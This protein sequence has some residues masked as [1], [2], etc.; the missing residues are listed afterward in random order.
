MP[1]PTSLVVDSKTDLLLPPIRSIPSV[2]RSNLLT[3]M[4]ALSKDLFDKG[5]TKN[6]N[7]NKP[8]IYGTLEND[9]INAQTTVE[10][11]EL[12]EQRFLGEFADNGI[13]YISGKGNDTI[14]GSE[15]D[16][17]LDTGI[18][19]DVLD[20]QRGD[21]VL[22]GGE[23]NDTYY[24]DSA[25]DEIAEL[26]NQG[27]DKLYTSV[28]YK[29]NDNAEVEKIFLENSVKSF[30][31]NK[32]DNDI[33]GNQGANTIKGGEGNDKL[34][35]R[36]GNDTLH[37][38]DDKDRIHGGVGEDKLFGDEGDDFLYG[39]DGNDTIEGGAG[40]DLI[41]GDQGADRLNGGMG[42]DLYLV[43]SEDTINDSG[44][45]GIVFLSSKKLTGG[46]RTED[47]PENTY[48]STDG[49]F[50]YVKNGSTL[51]ING[52][53]TINN[54][55]NGAL[56]IHL[57]TEDEDE[58]D[59]P[60]FD[61]PEKVTSPIIIDLD[62]D[63][64]ETLSINDKHYFDHDGNAF[65]ESTGW[66]SR[67]DGLLVWDK[68]NNGV[69]D[70][71]AELFG[72]Q[73]TLASGKKAKQGYE[74]L[75]EFD[76]NKDGVID[77]QDAIY[78][79]LS[80]WQDKN[81]N[82]LTDNDEIT[83]LADVGIKSVSTAYKASDHIDAEGNEHRQTSDVTWNDGRKTDSA[84]VWFKT[85][86]TRRVT[87]ET[88]NWTHEI[89]ALPNSRG[90]G[91]LPDLQQAMTQDETLLSMVKAFVAESD[92]Q[93]RNDM[94]LEIIY[95]WAGVTDVD[96]HSRD[97]KKVYGHVIDARKVVT[98]EKL[99]GRGYLGTWCWGERD[100]NPHGRAAPILK[101]EFDKFQRSVTAQ[102]NT[103]VLFDDT[104]L[105]AYFES[106]S[107]YF[108]LN[109]EALETYLASLNRPDK[110]EELNA[111]INT[112][113]NLGVYSKR[114]RNEVSSVLAKI[115][116]N[117]PSLNE[118]INHDT[119]AGDERDN[120]LRDYNKIN[121]IHGKKGNDTLYGQDGD[122]NYIFAKGDG[123]DTIYDTSGEDTLYFA[124][125]IKQ[126]NIGFKR[127][128]TDV[129]VVLLDDDGNPTGDEIKLTNFFD[130]DGTLAE[131][132]IEKVH[133]SDG[134]LVN[135]YDLLKQAATAA[136]EN[137][138]HLFGLPD[139]D[140]V[141]ALGGNDKISTYGGDDTIDGGA[142]DDEILAGD[143][144]DT[145]IGGTGNDTLVGEEGS[146]TYQFSQ[147]FGQD[148]I[149]NLSKDQTPNGQIVFDNTLTPDQI[150]VKRA[151]DDLQLI[152]SAQ[153]II[154]VKGYFTQDASTSAAVAEIQFADGTVWD[155]EAIKQQVLQPS[156]GDDY[157][158][159]YGSDDVF[160]GQAGND[161][162]KGLG[163]NDQLSGGEG[164]DQLF[165]D[166]GNDTLHGGQGNDTLRGG[167]D[168]D[169][170]HGDEGHDQLYGDSGNDQLF[171][172]AGNDRLEG[173]Y[174]HDQLAGGE[175]KDTLIGGIGNDQLK[176]DAG[177]DT[178]RG[179]E[180]DDQLT[181]GRGND[182]LAGGEGDDWYH[183]AKG[184]GQDVIN[185][186]QGQTTIVVYNLKLEDVIFR[187][188]DLA[189]DVTFKGNDGD[190]IRLE[191]VFDRQT[192]T[193]RFGLRLQHS[194]GTVQ[195]LKAEDIDQRAITATE[196]KDTLYGNHQANEINTLRGD[197]T[198]YAEGGDDFIRG[199]AGNDT[200]YGQAG[201]DTLRGGD[202]DDQLYGGVGNDLLQA[203]K[204]D[205]QLR[206][207][208]GDDQLEGGL[209][210]D[211]LYG[212]QGQDILR[213]EQGDDQLEGGEGDDQ[214][215]YQVGDG[216]DVIRDTQG[217]D[218]L[219]L[220]NIRLD[221]LL[222]RRTG[223]QYRY[224]PVEGETSGALSLAEASMSRD[225]DGDLLITHKGTGQTI[226]INDQ[227]SS[228]S[229]EAPNTAIESIQLKDQTLDIAAIKQQA[230]AGTATDDII[231]GHVDD[232]TI[233]AGGGDDQVFAGAGDDQ[234]HG[235][236]GQD[237]LYGE[238]G[239][240]QLYGD[241]GDDQLYGQSGDDQL[242][243]GAGQ[244]TLH[245]GQGDDQ[246]YG[247]AGND[248]LLGGEGQDTLLGGDGDDTLIAANS[249][250]DRSSNTLAGGKGNDTLYGGAGD[251]IYQFNLGDGHDLI[252]E[253]RRDE[254][255]T[256]HQPS[257]DVLL[258]GEG[259]S[260]DDLQFF[261]VNDDLQARHRNGQDQVTIQNWFVSFNNAEHD[262]FKV[263]TFRF[264]DGSELNTTD[265]ESQITWEGSA[266]D[267][268]FIGYRGYSET[269]K[270]GDG[271]DKVFTRE[272]DDI[273][274]GEGGDD[275]LDG[276]AG[277]DQ[278]YGGEGNDNLWGKQGND[279]L[280]GGIGDDSLSGNE[281]DDSL[282]G[283]AGD[284]SLFGGSGNDTLEGG[285]G[286]D[287]MEAGA[288]DDTLQGG[289]GDDQL[290]GGAG[291]DQLAGGTGSDKYIYSGGYDVIDN[292]GGGFD[293]LF[294]KD[295]VQKDDFTFKQDGDDL[296]VF[297]KDATEPAVRVV[298]HFLGEDYAI[299]Y[300]QPDG[301]NYITTAE[302]N[303]RA[304]AGDVEG[305]YDA[306]V[307]G[308]ANAD[309][310]GGTE[311][312]DLIQGLGGNDQLF[313]M[314]GDDV[315]QGG[316]GDDF[317]SGGNGS[318]GIADG[319]DRL[320]GGAGNDRLNGGGGNDTLIG[321]EGDDHYYFFANS[322]Q[323][324]IDNTGGG[325][326]WVFFNEVGR[327]RIS[328]H[329]DGDDLVMLVD[330]DLQ[331]KLTVTGHFTGGDQAISYIQPGDGG[332]AIPSSRIASLLTDL[333]A[334]GDT[335]TGD[336]NNGG[337][338]NGAGEGGD[339][340][341]GT[342][343]G[344]GDNGT[345]ETDNGD[346]DNGSDEVIDPSRYDTEV[347]GTAQG[348]QLVGRNN[349]NLIRGLAGDDTLFGMGGDD[350][351]LGG[352]GDDFIQGGNGR[353]N[354]DDGNDTLIG[355]A[356]NDVLAGFAGNDTL[357]GG[358]GDDHYY[359]HAQGGQ[360]I[361]DNT[362]G[363]TDWVF[364]IDIDRERIGY[365]RN[366]DDLVMLVDNDLQQK[367]T[368]TGHF[369]GGDKAISY[370]QPGD[371]GYAIPSSRLEGMLTELPVDGASVVA[372]DVQPASHVNGLIS[373]MAS[374]TD[375]GAGEATSGSLVTSNDRLVLTSSHQ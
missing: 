122:D 335:D 316:E 196:G 288:G 298:K 78:S 66:V 241:Q 293:G 303:R 327:D 244:D 200:L 163:G 91:N 270:A 274:Y 264:A 53:L 143:G 21:D 8:I 329:R 79:S 151:N 349:R 267:D 209:G 369:T 18:G 89:L 269:F 202:G 372:A 332:Y 225:R 371:G 319:N 237:L 326:D 261:R 7:G 128:L 88:F 350:I 111:A 215:R 149:Q 204:G 64:V 199:A 100:P 273:A 277:N 234:V 43:D 279:Q 201:N 102:L 184:D 325:N 291:N 368:V 250:W 109:E 180:G 309:K 169:I 198:V 194:D 36:E 2:V 227:F 134:T 252:V 47:D 304:K 40:K 342:D 292:Q 106:G 328:Y 290:G 153:D 92:Y 226:R 160:A 45:D 31:G 283:E 351:L 123:Q 144:N 69:V 59:E 99:V 218:S 330:N 352:D 141:S 346:N 77:A 300:V 190:R 229:T 136:T 34:F 177:D 272:G 206:G 125:G 197:D 52:G 361:I 173:S 186:Q 162:L 348:E 154:T 37:G 370:I 49:Q 26:E 62:G 221:D 17:V 41:R 178:L 22:I 118:Y 305:D 56:G 29:L 101:A 108:R 28:D 258:F 284:D 20:G 243:G 156:S 130:F 170:L 310:L 83:S 266:A 65:A 188:H 3:K 23:G 220:E 223:D 356:G 251:E 259:I 129:W 249:V 174:G 353:M 263:E 135:L 195:T 10:D 236:Q 133:L 366:G 189:L 224:N 295:G 374:M 340:G 301:G 281:G 19:D 35:G 15:N 324:V 287:F 232:D 276:E 152:A 312:N 51:V 311:G 212:G 257:Q 216:H 126:E 307:E 73:T 67:D 176:G 1:D 142:G 50:T 296:L 347:V 115:V 217:N 85:N 343:N 278:L 222:I 364:F 70:S 285:A 247:D 228:R 86:T 55:S 48:Y 355:G 289:D 158:E 103:Q 313:G 30:E 24:V 323:D 121:I 87:T 127:T 74:A 187:R 132:Q 12:D 119:V 161:T 214:Y 164:D 137:D 338:D 172:G 63:G 120:V 116:L 185:D 256:N 105:S 210:N 275:Y 354:G 280:F 138:D 245:G 11:I 336:T 82:G 294:F 80:V 110:V 317:L 145:L 72:N 306:V 150:T 314:L 265:I 231:M 71:G 208:D 211:T 242:H 248:R 191:N 238:Q 179:D 148:S 166:D 33:S 182:Q 155:V 124:E 367:L 94:V 254:A 255:F 39:G 165:G 321:G 360:D 117:H 233:Q 61:D 205:D 75:A 96:P 359:Y 318:N 207:E 93:K 76:D 44:K 175:G 362:G 9:V 203:H 32:Y 140:N 213:G 345:G 302:I 16:D 183:F 46:E 157:I 25:G 114:I 320:E 159:G 131:G 104:I 112:L 107:R 358:V 315:V 286:N 344:T 181:G 193:A 38:G 334:G 260:A 282:S 373:A 331:Q 146:D 42:K 246:L 97:P 297:V 363:G 5:I 58:D 341:T 239:N 219:H 60:D 262:Y 235:G 98:L 339:T 57:E 375:G 6:L 268:K 322:G 308:T 68:N 337:T 13:Y 240:D 90:Y 54:Y 333:P 365:H 27:D 95:Q 230:L 299:D 192:L 167:K 168:D 171:G 4:R 271:N 14:A 147:G 253:T 84:D 113:Q 139:A 81:E 357:Q